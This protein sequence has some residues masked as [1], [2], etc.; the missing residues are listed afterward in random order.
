MPYKYAQIFK[1]GNMKFDVKT[2]W[3]YCIYQWKLE[4]DGVVDNMPLLL[5]DDYFVIYPPQPN[6]EETKEE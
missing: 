2:N 5:D 6:Y 4:N 3:H 1:M